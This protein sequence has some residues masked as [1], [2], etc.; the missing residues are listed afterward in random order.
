MTFSAGMMSSIDNRRA[1]DVAYLDLCN[2]FNLVP[3]HILIFELKKDVFEGWI[4]F[5]DK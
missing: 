5:V 1:T 3:H 4:I 2:A